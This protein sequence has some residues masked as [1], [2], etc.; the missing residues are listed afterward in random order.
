M[1]TISEQTYISDHVRKISRH[2]PFLNLCKKY[3]PE[4]REVYY[5]KDWDNDEIW[6]IKHERGP[7]QNNEPD[8]SMEIHWFQMAAMFIPRR[9]AERC[10]EPN[11]QADKFWTALAYC[12]SKD[13]EHIIDFLLRW[14]SLIS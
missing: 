9:M 11:C 6:F 5:G 14:D 8:D 3:F 2:E 1:K 13:E 10:K 7:G 4:Y 12:L